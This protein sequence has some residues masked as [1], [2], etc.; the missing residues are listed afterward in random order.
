MRAYRILVIIIS[1]VSISWPG[2]SQDHPIIDYASQVA[3]AGSTGEVP[4]GYAFY[5]FGP[6]TAY[7]KVW[8]F[9]S[10]GEDAIW[11][12]KES[13]VE[14]SDWSGVNTIFDS[15]KSPLFNMTFDG[16]YFHFIRSIAGDLN[17]R[18]GKAQSDGSIQF[19]PEVTAYRDSTWQLR[20]TNGA[21][22]RHFSIAVDHEKHVWIALKVG[23]GDEIVSNFKPIAIASVATDGSWQN[24]TGFPIDLDDSFNNRANARAFN[25]IEI[26]PGKIL[27][28]WVNYRTTLSHA[29]RGFRARLWSDGSLGSIEVTGLTYDAAAS[30]VVV[31]QPGIALVNSGMEVA[32]R[33]ADGSWDRIDPTGMTSSSWN[34]LTAQGGTVRL[35][36]VSGINIRYRE[37]QNNG[38]TWGTLTT[39]WTAQERIFHINGSH[40]KYNQGTHHSLLWA[41][42]SS[43][44]D[45]YMGIEGSYDFTSVEQ[46]SNE[47]P[48]AFLLYQNY[49][50]PFNPSTLIRYELPVRGYVRLSVYNSLGQNVTQLVN[51]EHEA[52]IYEVAF[53]A[54]D[55]PSGVYIY[56]LHVGEYVESKKLLLLR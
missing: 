20:T 4:V 51:E 48:S 28:C 38:T 52:G 10:D 1:L 31:P 17:Y 53:D 19:D 8:V 26:A 24:R 29:Q 30:S 23:D 47:I 5:N 33:N 13:P 55:L 3:N 16:E 27:F 2:L 14:D 21:V 15:V 40:A 12:T 42:G 37:T 45:I 7:D 56:R 25:V 43:P 6:Y 44:Y 9:Y 35:W 50:N 54:S 18:R 32:R 22:P 49:P 11:R 41:T 39:K 46:I 34:V 36:D